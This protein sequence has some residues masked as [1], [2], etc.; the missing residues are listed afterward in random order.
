MG[1]IWKSTA[2]IT[3][4]SSG[5]GL[6][7]AKALAAKGWYVVMACRDVVKGAKA[8]QDLQIPEENYTVMEIDLASLDSVRQFVKTFRDRGRSLEALVCN[9][10]VYLPLQKEPL[11]SPDGYELSVATNHLGHFLLCNLMLDDLRRSP[12]PTKRLVILG[13]VTA[14]SKELGGKIPIPAPPDLGDLQGFE[15]GF[16][17][18]IAMIN[19]KKFKSGKA[20]KDSK[21]CNMLT[22]RELHR[23]YHNTTGIVVSSI[24]PGCVA[25]TPLFRNHFSLFRTI[26]PWFQ[27]NITKGYVTQELA[28]ERL[29]EVVAD[30]NYKQSGVHWSWGNRQQEGREAF[31]QEL[32]AE[33]SD[34]AKAKKMWELSEKL[35]GLA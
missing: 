21:L 10:A 6:Y 2:I 12:V 31:V 13:T 29:A 1:D 28:G 18:P 33:G 17:E 3:G 27:K 34:D 26:F 4:A 30:R 19:G 22:A 23:R 16:K 11:R 20:Y 15:A 35:V 8:A 9:A 14:N 24:Y 5:V 7:G 25:D 32:S